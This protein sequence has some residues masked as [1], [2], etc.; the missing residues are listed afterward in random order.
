MSLVVNKKVHL[1]YE[2]LDTFSCGIELLGFE[3][4]A[5]K[6]KYGSLDGAYV[7]TKGN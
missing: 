2:V 7:L 4:K 6:A 1:N 3:V 5:I